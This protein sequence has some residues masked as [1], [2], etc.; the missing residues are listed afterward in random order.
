MKLK[1]WPFRPVHITYDGGKK[2]PRPEIKKLTGVGII[3]NE[4]LE[5]IQTYMC[6]NLNNPTTIIEF[7][8]QDDVARTDARPPV[9]QLHPACLRFRE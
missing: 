8:P 2:A 1:K 3:S 5:G 9:F 4:Y 6:A 7:C